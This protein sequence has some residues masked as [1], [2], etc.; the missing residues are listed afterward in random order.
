MQFGYDVL[1]GTSYDFGIGIATDSQ[2]NVYVTGSY[3][4]I[5]TVYSSENNSGSAFTLSNAGDT[6]A[7]IVKYDTSGT[8]ATYTNP[9][10][11]VIC[12]PRTQI[13]YLTD[14]TLEN[15]IMTEKKN[16]TM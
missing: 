15:K 10:T 3:N 6:D 7:F 1:E 12:L 2:G 14:N 4:D 8:N 16:E 11:K 9:N 13:G 5:A